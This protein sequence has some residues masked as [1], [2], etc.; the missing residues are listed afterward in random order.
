MAAAAPEPEPVRKPEAE[1]TPAPPASGIWSLRMR[2]LQNGVLQEPR[3]FA[4]LPF[5]WLLVFFVAILL[6]VVVKNPELPRRG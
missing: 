3:V 5:L 2:L 4:K 1:A 6:W